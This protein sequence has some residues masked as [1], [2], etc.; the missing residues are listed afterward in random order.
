MCALHAFAD[1]S[2]KAY[3]TVAYLQSGNQVD[4]VMAKTRVC[5]L[6]KTTLPR[7]ELWAIAI[8][9]NLAKFIISELQPQLSN[10]N[11]E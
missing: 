3:G 9:A 8:A 11:M 6:K 4:L 2:M 1:A 5:P 7:L 10:V